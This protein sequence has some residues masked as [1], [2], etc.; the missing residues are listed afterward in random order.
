M[1]CRQQ[2]QRRAAVGGR[3][4]VDGLGSRCRQAAP[5]ALALRDARR[6]GSGEAGGA[7]QT[8]G[9]AD[10]AKEDEQKGREKRRSVAEDIC[11]R[12]G[13]ARLVDGDLA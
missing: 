13:E 7:I 1:C 6:E 10:G 9:R 8:N 4:S 3:D 2:Q 5:L 11:W 12:K